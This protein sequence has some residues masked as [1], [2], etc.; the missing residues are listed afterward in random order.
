[1]LRLIGLFDLILRLCSFKFPED[2]RTAAYW[3]LEANVRKNSIFSR[4]YS[5]F[6]SLFK[7][8]VGRL[9]RSFNLCESLNIF[10]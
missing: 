6:L 1:M 3:F 10:A 9:N 4:C 5:N 8:L 7:L 2:N